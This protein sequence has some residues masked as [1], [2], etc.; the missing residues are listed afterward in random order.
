MASNTRKLKK[1]RAINKARSGKARKNAVRR[2]GTTAESL[3]L[4]KPNA[5]EIAQKNA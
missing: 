5:N 4:N 2:N 1:R 3:P